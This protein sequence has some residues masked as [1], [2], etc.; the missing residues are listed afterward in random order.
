[1]T[2]PVDNNKLE[3]LV[4]KMLGDLGGAFSVPTVRIGFR[5]GLFEAL[6]RHGPA[7]ISELTARTGQAERYVRE[8][9]LAQAANGY[10]D[11][12]AEQERFRLTPEQAMVF[13]VKDSPV[14]LEGAFDL[15]ASMVEAQPKVEAAF[16]TGMALVGAK[17]AAAYSVRSACSS[18]RVTSTASS[19]LGCPH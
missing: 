19:S 7:R 9:A 4:G 2:D 6:H 13:A 3:A 5:T 10:I 11:F 8:W 15:A 17:A 14:Y 1:M 16:R 18:G 12:D